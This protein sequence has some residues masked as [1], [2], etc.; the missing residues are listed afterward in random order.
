ML[1]VGIKYSLHD[2]ISESVSVREPRSCNL[3]NISV[4]AYRHNN[5]SARFASVPLSKFTASARPFVRCEFIEHSFMLSLF[6]HLHF[7]LHLLYPHSS[8]KQSN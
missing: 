5:N 8:F 7:R 2:L 4:I 6:L 3:G 1:S